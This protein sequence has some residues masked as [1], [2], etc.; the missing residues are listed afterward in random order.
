MENIDLFARLEAARL[1]IYTSESTSP[2]ERCGRQ[3]IFDRISGTQ[4]DTCLLE[5]LFCFNLNSNSF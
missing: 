5:I 3:V 2:M 1:V 4:N